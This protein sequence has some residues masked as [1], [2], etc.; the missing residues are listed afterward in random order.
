ME[1]FDSLGSLGNIKALSNAEYQQATARGQSYASNNLLGCIGANPAHNLLG[2][3]GAN[4]AYWY[5]ISPQMADA[6]R[7]ATP[8][9]FKAELRGPMSEDVLRRLAERNKNRVT[10]L[11]R[12]KNNV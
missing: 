1:P 3:S 4:P 9:D 10:A 7:N 5:E 6:L 12:T 8:Q 2:C 11:A